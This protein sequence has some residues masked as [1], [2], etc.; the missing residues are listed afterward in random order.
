VLAGLL[1]VV[2]TVVVVMGKRSGFDG[3]NDKGNARML[4]QR[5]SFAASLRA[6]RRLR[7]GAREFE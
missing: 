4:T 6:A 3:W 2:L 1:A 5:L 7:F